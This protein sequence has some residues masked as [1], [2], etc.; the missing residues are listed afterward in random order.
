MIEF[1]D[2]CSVTLV[3]GDEDGDLWIASDA[4]VSTRSYGSY[5]QNQV[6]DA[7]DRGLVRSLMRERHGTPFEAPNFTFEIEAPI[8]VARESHRHRMIS[9][10]EV[11]GRYVELAPVFWTPPANRPLVQTGKAMAYHLEQ[12]EADL[13][14]LVDTDVRYVCVAA[15]QAYQ[16]MLEAGVAKEI[17][18]IVLPLNLMTRW[19]ARGNLRAWLNYLSLRTRDERATYESKPMLEIQEVAIQIEAILGVHCPAALAAFNEFG[20]VAP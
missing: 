5:E 7:R 11:S 8:F 13:H 3:R 6:D 9:V 14:A 18:R 12:G 4:R 2:R 16:Q 20:R 17:A 15:W 1:K 10:S 19:R